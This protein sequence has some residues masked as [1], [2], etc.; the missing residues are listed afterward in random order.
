MQ[1]FKNGPVQDFGGE[2]RYLQDQLEG[3][4]GALVCAAGTRFQAA[5]KHRSAD[6]VS[7][8]WSHPARA[9]DS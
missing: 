5:C 6:T 2:T 3:K 8:R 9:S 4:S 1:V 7:S